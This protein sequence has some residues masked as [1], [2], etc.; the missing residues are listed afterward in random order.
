MKDIA[1]YDYAGMWFLRHR[2]AG[3]PVC[4][5]CGHPNPKVQVLLPVDR[6]QEGSK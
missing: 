2:Y 4:V 6:A 3:Q 1:C 5:R